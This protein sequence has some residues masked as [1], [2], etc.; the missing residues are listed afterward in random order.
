MA[1][2]SDDAALAAARDVLLAGGHRE[3][4]LPAVAGRLGVEPGPLVRRW[5][6]ADALLVEALAWTM[7]IRD[8]PAEADT[9]QQLR[10]VVEVLMGGYDHGAR[11]EAALLALLADPLTPAAVVAELRDRCVHRRRAS[12]AVVLRRVADRGDLP[13]DTDIGLVLD[14]W[15][16]AI[17]YRRVGSGVPVT[18]DHIGQ[19][20]DLVLSGMAPLQG[21]PV[22]EMPSAGLAEPPDW[23]YPAHRFLGSFAFGHVRP[24][25]ADVP[26]RELRS[27]PR[28]ATIAGRPVSVSALAGRDFMPG[29]AG[30]SALH[31]MVTVAADGTAVLPPGIHADRIAVLSRD[32]VWVAPLGQDDPRLRTSR[33]FQLSARMGPTWD[34]GSAVD[35]V[36]QVRSD[37]GG[38][39]LLQVPAVSID[40]YS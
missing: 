31:V 16:G 29:A 38:L 5:G 32:E 8:I 37:N 34:V 23:L 28:S 2:V 9:R 30:R 18:G 36:V 26:V 39:H 11:A 6:S 17:A 22:P 33:S 14:V 24:V 15:S 21:W 35:V 1:E 27:A 40:S 3:F 4:S 12:A 10:W 7:T 13:P 19:L 20:V 25:T